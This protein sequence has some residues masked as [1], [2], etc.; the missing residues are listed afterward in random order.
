MKMKI[1]YEQKTWENLKKTMIFTN[2]SRK[3]SNRNFI[4]T[5]WK[6]K[7]NLGGK[8]SGRFRKGFGKVLAKF[9]E[10]SGRFSGRL[11]R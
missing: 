7:G 1:M 5:S 10:V 9:Q 11:C 4:E 6:S 8:V 2:R 3:K